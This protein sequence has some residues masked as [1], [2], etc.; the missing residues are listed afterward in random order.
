VG[1]EAADRVKGQRQYIAVIT[2]GVRGWHLGWGSR[3][4]RCEG[5]AAVAA[6]GLS[7]AFG[8]F[9]V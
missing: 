4:A 8:T 5:V 6:D 7:T 9:G 1:P 3:A 2:Q